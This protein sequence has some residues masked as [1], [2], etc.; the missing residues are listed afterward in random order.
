VW[1]DARGGRWSF[2]DTSP[3]RVGWELRIRAAV[4]G[5]SSIPIY[6]G[7]VRRV[8]DQ[9]ARSTFRLGA[10]LIDRLADLGAVDLPEQ[11]AAA[12][13]DDLT[14]ARVLRVLD[15]AGINRAYATM[16]TTFDNSGVV[17]HQSS[18]FARN[19]LDEAY[20]AVD[21]EAG[22][23]LLADRDGQI[24]YRRGSWWAEVPGH[25]PNPRW[26][27]TRATWTN[28]ETADPN[29]F[30]VLEPGGFGTG[31]DLDDVRNQISAARTG[32]TAITVED[33]NS[34]IAYGVRTF[35]RFDLT[36][37]YDADVSA[38]A[39]LYLAQLSARTE[40]LDALEA[41][42]DPRLPTLE[43]ERWLDVELGDRHAIRWTDGDGLVSGT[44][45]VHGIRHRIDPGHWR[46]GLDLWAYNGFGLAPAAAWGSAVW[47]TSRWQ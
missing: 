44:F 25:P 7:T 30:D 10:E 32:G 18:T 15:L 37:R 23:D 26:N 36:C 5:R 43:L 28:V 34:K 14:H 12:G 24:V 3:V 21:S 29:T 19:L 20:S 39:N 11:A 6:R 33:A 22:S 13:L 27:A 2:R 45:H 41:E 17:H 42:L 31:S 4:D 8:R 1:R 47:G 46:L 16:G 9:W 40:R 35:Q 38:F